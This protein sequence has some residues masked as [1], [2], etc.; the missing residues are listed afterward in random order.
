MLDTRHGWQSLQE[1]FPHPPEPPGLWLVSALGQM[2][3][4]LLLCPA[5]N[6]HVRQFL[7]ST[8]CSRPPFL[9]PIHLRICG[10]HSPSEPGL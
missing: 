9:L 8:R 4:P 2:C 5:L 10:P 6:A 7:L 3:R 1:A